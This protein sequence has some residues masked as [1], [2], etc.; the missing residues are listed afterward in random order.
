MLKEF[1][2]TFITNLTIH[3][4]E[5]TLHTPYSIGRIQ[6]KAKKA[7]NWHITVCSTPPSI[8]KL[9]T[10]ANSVR[11]EYN[12]LIYSI[13]ILADITIRFFPAYIRLR[14]YLPVIYPTTRKG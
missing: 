14:V 10:L 1:C 13:S 4:A 3:L 8:P 9:H 2:P 6:P 5:H 7:I 12:A 11:V